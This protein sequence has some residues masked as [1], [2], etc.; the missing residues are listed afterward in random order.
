[1]KQAKKSTRIQ[2]PEDFP[3]SMMQ[4]K[5]MDEKE[6][7]R[8]AKIIAKHKATNTKKQAGKLLQKLDS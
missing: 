4:Y 5:P 3:G 8:A 7:E 6:T 2:G 1:M